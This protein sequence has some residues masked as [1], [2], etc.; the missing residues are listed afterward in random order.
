MADSFK[1]SK[2]YAK[3]YALQVENEIK[4]RL[5]NNGKVSSGKLFDSIKASVKVEHNDILVKFAMADYGKYVDKG[6]TGAGIPKGFNGEKKKVNKSKQYRFGKKM[7]PEKPIKDWMRIQ[8][9]PKQALFPIRRS[10]WIFGIAPTQF[11][12]IPTT[13]RQKQFE[14][15]ME[16]ALLKDIEDALKNV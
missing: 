12:T 7:P 5:V 9:I 1:H 13:R 14:L 15:G 6:V 16:K 11:F 10:I 2:E 4:T 3:R 8:G